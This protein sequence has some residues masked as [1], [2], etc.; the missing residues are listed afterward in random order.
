VAE[1][2][3]GARSMGGHWPWGRVMFA[4][5]AVRVWA[6][7]G[8]KVHLRLCERLG[9]ELLGGLELDSFSLDVWG[10]TDQLSQLLETK[11]LGINYENY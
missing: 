8:R 10:E 5:V 9:C 6:A 11:S 4:F 7:A 3:R 1:R 2:E